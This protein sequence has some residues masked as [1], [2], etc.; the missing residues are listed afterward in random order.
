MKLQE[1][2]RKHIEEKGIM[3]KHVADKSGIPQK[4]FYR[5]MNGKTPMSVDEYELIC[6]KGLA[7]DPSFFFKQKVSVNEKSQSA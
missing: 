5:L 1:R 3:L 6:K 7:V 4:K 2:I